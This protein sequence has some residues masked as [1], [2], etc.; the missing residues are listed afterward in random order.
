[1]PAND[2]NVDQEALLE[3]LQVGQLSML[4]TH[5]AVSYVAMSFLQVDLNANKQQIDDHVKRVLCC[6]ILTLTPIES[7][8][9]IFI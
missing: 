1:M 8:R 7:T 5:C 9:C 2:Y 6:S 4:S 3:C